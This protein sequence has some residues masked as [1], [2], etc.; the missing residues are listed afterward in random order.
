MK[1]DLERDIQRLQTEHAIDDSLIQSLVTSTA[2]A[3]AHLKFW[4]R[5]MWIVNGSVIGMLALIFGFAAR[6]FIDN[7]SL[8]VFAIAVIALCGMIWAIAVLQ[9][10]RQAGRAIL[11]MAQKHGLL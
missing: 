9:R 1:P 2:Q 10:Q 7:G 4:T 8:W 6:S 5:T 3:Q 11:E